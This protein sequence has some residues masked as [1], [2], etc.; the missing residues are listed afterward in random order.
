MRV[1]VLGMRRLTLA[2]ARATL[3]REGFTEAPPG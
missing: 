1:G 3:P 2:F